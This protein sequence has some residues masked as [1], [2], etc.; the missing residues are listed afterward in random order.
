MDVKYMSK[1][2]PHM[3]IKGLYDEEEMAKIQL[4]LDYIYSNGNLLD[5]EDSWAAKDSDGKVKKQNKA[6]SL[7]MF[8]TDRKYSNILWLNRN[9]WAPEIIHEVQK[10]N[11]F[12]MNYHMTSNADFTLLS[13]YENSD[14]YKPHWD[15]AALTALTWFWKEPKSFEGGNLYFSDYDYTVEVELGKCILFPSPINHAVEEV[16]MDSEMCGKGYGR[17]VMTQFLSHAGNGEP[18]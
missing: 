5:P 1:P 14:Y 8:Y 15:Q 17:W 18:Q 10:Q 16:K 7:D 9:L 4:E 13:Y 2:F 3:I 12:V 11:N 6:I